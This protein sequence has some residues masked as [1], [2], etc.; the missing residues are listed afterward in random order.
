MDFYPSITEK[1]LNDS[2]KFAQTVCKI[3]ENEIHIIKHACKSVLFY[4][5]GT[6]VKK[7][8]SGLF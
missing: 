1:L 6:W 8:K 7:V 4:N 3:E 2:I 5:G